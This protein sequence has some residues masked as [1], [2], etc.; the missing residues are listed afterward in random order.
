MLY[1]ELV[2]QLAARWDMKRKR[3]REL[4]EYFFE[5]II[6]ITDRENRLEIRGFGVFEMR[7]RK[8]TKGRI[9]GTGREVEVPPRRVPTFKPAKALKEAAREVSIKDE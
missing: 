7:K 8:Q 4:V 9:P 1:S 5:N 6:D 2:D 3:A